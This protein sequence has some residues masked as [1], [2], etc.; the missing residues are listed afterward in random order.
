MFSAWLPVSLLAGML[1]G[2]RV[3][4]RLYLAWLPVSLLAGMLHGCRVDGLQAY[5]MVE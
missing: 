4:G 2:C 5:C 3:D 1:H